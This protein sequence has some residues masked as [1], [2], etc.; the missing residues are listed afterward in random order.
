MDGL[1]GA[2]GHGLEA[3][4]LVVVND[5]AAAFARNAVLLAKVNHGLAAHQPATNKC[6]F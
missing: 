5:F 1:A 4:F 2:I 6:S 3:M